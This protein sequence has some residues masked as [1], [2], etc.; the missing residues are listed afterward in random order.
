VLI[1]AQTT[2]SIISPEDGR[3]CVWTSMEVPTV[4]S[5]KRPLSMMELQNVG[6]SLEHATDVE[7]RKVRPSVLPLEMRRLT[8]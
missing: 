6:E 5:E 1:V 7:L 2:D 4:K 3:H 8:S